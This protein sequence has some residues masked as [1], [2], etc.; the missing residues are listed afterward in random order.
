T[1]VVAAPRD[2][3]NYYRPRFVGELSRNFCL[4]KFACQ[5]NARRDRKNQTIFTIQ[6]AHVLVTDMKDLVLH[7][8][9]RTIDVGQKVK[10]E[11]VIDLVEIRFGIASIGTWSA[12][13][14]KT[15]RIEN[16]TISDHA[17]SEHMKLQS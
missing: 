4:A 11:V 3:S 16:G 17:I 10:I 1:V 13:V 8:W 5:R 9:R 15:P 14:C 2:A 7:C 6:C 12:F